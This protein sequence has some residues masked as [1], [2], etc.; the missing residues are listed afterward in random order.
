MFLNRLNEITKPTVHAKI[1]DLGFGDGP[2]TV[3][4]R[5][6]TFQERQDIFG[7]RAKDDGTLELRGEGRYLGAEVI[8]ASLCDEHGKPVATVEAVRKWKD[9]LVDTLSAAAMEVMQPAKDE[10][11]TKGAN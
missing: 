4:F 11:P 5:D 2:E 6:L 9:K 7:A 10:N 3:H 1:I 8:A